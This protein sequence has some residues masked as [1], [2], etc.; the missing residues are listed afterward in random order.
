MEQAIAVADDDA[1]L[2]ELYAE[3][4]FQTMA[5]AGMWGRAPPADLVAP[6]IERALELAAPQTAARAKAL[7]ARCYADY[8]KSADD[9]AEASAIAD[10]LGQPVLRSRGYDVRHLVAFVHGDYRE[11]LEWCRR[12]ES[13]VHELDDPDT[14]VYVYAYGITPAVACGELDEARRYARLHDEA[15]R[16]LSPHH[17]L[18]GSVL[19][20]LVEELL[21]NWEQALELQEQIEDRVAESVATPCVLSARSLY[22][23][24]LA[25]LYLGNDGE[26]RRLEGKAEPLAMSGYGTVLDTPPLLIA[27][28]RGDLAAVELLLGEPAVRAT[29]WLYLSSMAAH[30]DGGTRRR[31]SRPEGPPLRRRPRPLPRGRETPSRSRAGRARR[32]TARGRRPRRRTSLAPDPR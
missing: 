18:H 6:W 27:L 26:A 19:L 15:A 3:L 20:L 32:S 9:A 14:A 17:R 23:C 21:G 11:A 10:R 2:A 25:N 1:A 24:A 5:R 22:V 29:N 4:A 13:F 8:D 31:R 7:I 28:H 12:R 30:L 16:P